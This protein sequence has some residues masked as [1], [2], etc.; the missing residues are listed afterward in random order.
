MRKIVPMP[1][2]FCNYVEGL[3]YET[4]A[5]R[6]VIAFMLNSAILNQERFD[7][8]HKEYLEFYAKYELVKNEIQKT[9]VDEVYG[10]QAIKWNLNFKTQELEIDLKDEK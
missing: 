6:D 10:N 1:E 5:R 4:N 3:M 7:Q 2:D 8:Y 9:Y